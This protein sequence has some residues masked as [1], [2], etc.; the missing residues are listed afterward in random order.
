MVGQA[1][2]VTAAIGLNVVALFSEQFCCQLMSGCGRLAAA[3]LIVMARKQSCF[4]G[5]GQTER[6]HSRVV[7]LFGYFHRMQVPCFDG[8]RFVP[9]GAARQRCLP[10]MQ[11]SMNIMTARPSCS[12]SLKR[13]PLDVASA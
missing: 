2:L 7:T 11:P 10:M 4:V 5:N 3:R 1:W 12:S 9:T 13:Y 8:P 6:G